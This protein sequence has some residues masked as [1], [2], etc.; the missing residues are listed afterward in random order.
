[1]IDV[2]DLIALVRNYN[3]RTNADLIRRAYAYGL[4][5]HDGQLR[6][7]GE[8]YFSHPIAV[9][10]I[11]T[12]Q[13]LDDATIVTA[14]LHDTIEDTKSTYTEVARLFGDEVAKLV[15]GVT[16]LT[17]LELSSAQS[18]QAENF[19]KLFMAMSED[20]FGQTG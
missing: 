19:R 11:L 12:E 7:S 8:P 4:Q 10:A 1:M 3:P 2:E 13:Q 16:K 9:A 18:Q 6:H 17:N 14:L 15:D 5:M 20:D